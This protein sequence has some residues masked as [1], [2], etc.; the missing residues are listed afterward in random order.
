MIK[1]SELFKR[2]YLRERTYKWDI[3]PIDRSW[4]ITPGGEV[5]GDVSH[6]LIYK[7]HFTKD[8]QTLAKRTN[9]AEAEQIIEKRLISMGYIKIGELDNFYAIV[10]EIGDHEKD[11]LHGFATSIKKVR[12]DTSQKFL[13]IHEMRS[14]NVERY[15]MQEIENDTLYHSD[16]T[17]NDPD[18]EEEGFL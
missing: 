5:W 14:G 13:A 17:W 2:L 6:R 4:I 3:D 7:T 10:W 8:F 15:I 16:T 12:D 9:D 11:V 18:E 1:E